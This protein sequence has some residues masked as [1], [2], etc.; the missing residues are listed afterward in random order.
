[1]YQ[2]GDGVTLIATGSEVH[3]AVGAASILEDQGI[4]ARGE[5]SPAGSCSSNRTRNTDPGS[6]VGALVAIE[7]ASLFGWE[8]I[9]GQDGLI[10][11]IDH[12][13]ESAYTSHCREGVHRSCGATGYGNISPPEVS[14]RPRSS[15]CGAGIAGVAAAH[16]SP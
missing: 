8:R 1:M 6:R 4:S 16:G 15:S 10:L 14:R 2:D 11:G 7:A 5:S 12:F 9:V 13:G 3:V